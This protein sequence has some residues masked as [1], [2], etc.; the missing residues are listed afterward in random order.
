L[1][2]HVTTSHGGQTYKF[3]WFVAWS[4]LVSAVNPQLIKDLGDVL[5][6]WGP[7][8]GVAFEGSNLAMGVAAVTVRPWSWYVLLVYQLFLLLWGGLYILIFKSDWK[9]GAMVAVLSLAWAI[10][11]FVY[12]Y[13]RRAFFRA[14]WRWQ[15][16]ERSWPRLVGPEIVSPDARPGIRGLSLLRRWLFAAATAIGVLVQ[17]L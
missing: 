4:G 2:T 11:C 9:N 14:R 5:S 12:F 17:Q 3:G 16:L 6:T 7:V 10:L 1:E 15:W 13:K 8:V